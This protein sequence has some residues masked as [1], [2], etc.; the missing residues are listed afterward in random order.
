MARRHARTTFVHLPSAWDASLPPRR[1]QAIRSL[2]TWSAA[3]P[4][5]AILA[6]ALSV[7]FGLAAIVAIFV[8]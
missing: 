7:L 5:L 4:T 1:P 2:P 6:A 3:F 8:L